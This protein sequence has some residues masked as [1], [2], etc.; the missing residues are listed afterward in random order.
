[1]LCTLSAFSPTRQARLALLAFLPVAIIFDMNSLL[2]DLRKDREARGKR[3]REEHDLTLDDDPPQASS[4]ALL[5]ESQAA[6]PDAEAVTNLC[7][8]GFPR[9]KAMAALNAAL[10]NMERAVDFLF[11]GIPVVTDEPAPPPPQQQRSS[12]SGNHQRTAMGTRHSSTLVPFLDPKNIYVNSLPGATIEP[13]SAHALPRSPRTITFGQ[14]FAGP[15]T[16]ALMTVFDHDLDFIC[17]HLPS[18]CRLQLIRTS[19]RSTP[20]PTQAVKWAR[21]QGAKYVFAPEPPARKASSSADADES[22]S[23]VCMHSKLH[24]LRFP[25]RLRVV[26]SSANQASGDWDHALQVTWVN[27]FFR[28]GAARTV[29]GG[30]GGNG[31]GRPQQP[32]APPCPTRSRATM[33]GPDEVHVLSSSSSS[34]DE[35]DDDVGAGAAAAPSVASAATAPSSSSSSSSASAPSQFASYLAEFVRRLCAA[36]PSEA[37][38]WLRAILEEHDVS[39]PDGV[40]LIGSV[41]GEWRSNGEPVQAAATADAAAAAGSA[42]SSG[43]FASAA[44]HPSLSGALA[45][46]ASVRVQG[47]GTSS[48]L[49]T[50]EGGTLSCECPSFKKERKPCKHIKALQEGRTE[51]RPSWGLHRLSA[52]LSGGRGGFTDADPIIFQVSSLS[53]AGGWVRFPL[54]KAAQGGEGHA[55]FKLVFPSVRRV[56]ASGGY[57]RSDGYG[58]WC[59]GL[60]HLVFATE[61]WWSKGGGYGSLR[62]CPPGCDKA[63]GSWNGKKHMQVVMHDLSPRPGAP[64][65]RA[66][67]LNHSKVMLRVDH[68]SGKGWIYAGSANMSG[69][70]WGIAKKDSS[71]SIGLYEL[72]VL[73]TDVTVSEYDVPFEYASPRAYDP[74]ADAPGGGYDVMSHVSADVRAQI[75][76]GS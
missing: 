44:A 33:D 2:A 38:P 42:A 16:H 41:P 43:G 76:R 23:R 49:I 20:A 53:S 74:V 17:A 7:S 47:S 30:A 27:D 13:G 8:M 73:L 67:F 64:L 31:G 46:G 62:G 25:D 32:G 18:G 19:S 3:P 45:D 22:S 40:H 54:Q 63:H 70:A 65:A 26:V 52:L 14:L 11:N 5:R 66:R 59:Y 50:N 12:S 68:G 1:M 51:Q 21:Y 56:L 37:D 72:G 24:L 28:K 48:Y 15:V 39:V 6:A 57:P 36:K 35:G 55:E 10:G 34:S 71:L 69:S 9:G 4:S 61:N 75:L 60:G 29:G 58:S